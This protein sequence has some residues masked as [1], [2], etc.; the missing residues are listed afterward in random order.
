MKVTIDSAAVDAHLSL[1][2]KKA[3]NLSPALN[4]VGASLAENI[5]LG[6]RDGESPWGDPFAPLKALRRNNRDPRI[7]DKP[8]NDT[9]Q[10]I[11]N[12]IT[13]HVSGGAV[14]VGMLENQPIGITHQFGSQKNNTPARPFMPI[15]PDGGVDLPIAWEAEIIGIVTAHLGQ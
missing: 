14:E 9:R 5:R 2:S 11:Y 7:S 8:L 3:G 15:R 1:L 10:H 12:R 6:I 4:D 13:Y